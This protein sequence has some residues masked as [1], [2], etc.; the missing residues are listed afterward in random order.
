M[1]RGIIKVKLPM[2]T[3]K[4]DEEFSL[5]QAGPRPHLLNN[6]C[7]MEFCCPYL[8]S[9]LSSKILCLVNNILYNNKTKIP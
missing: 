1:E 9:R 6:D 3:F 7:C 2:H 4:K 8:N 5:G